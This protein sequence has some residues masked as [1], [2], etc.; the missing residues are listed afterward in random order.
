ML[1]LAQAHC[2]KQTSIFILSSVQGESLETQPQD[3]SFTTSTEC[4]KLCQD[5]RAWLRENIGHILKAWPP[6]SALAPTSV[7][8]LGEQ[9]FSLY[10]GIGG[11]AYLHW[12]LSS[13]F[14]VEEDRENVE[15]HRRKAVEAMTVALSLLPKLSSDSIAFFIGGAGMLLD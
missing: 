1:G 2:Y 8:G 4:K 15:F 12:K 10:V 9:D 6:G 11:N 13:F 14:A 5:V 7:R 3:L